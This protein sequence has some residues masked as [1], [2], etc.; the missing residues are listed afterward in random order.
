MDGGIKVHWCC[1]C[2]GLQ[3]VP[4]VF[5]SSPS[6]EFELLC[7]ARVDQLLQEAYSFEEFLQQQK[8][9]IKG[10]LTALNEIL[11]TPKL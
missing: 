6:E 9:K 7:P 8:D 11:K 4:G 3:S 10:K 1:Y 2:Y 5:Y